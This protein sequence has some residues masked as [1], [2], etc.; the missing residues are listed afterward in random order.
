MDKKPKLV[1]IL[2][3][4]VLIY[5]FFHHA[6][7][8][9]LFAASIS[10]A[11]LL[12][13]IMGSL[14]ARLALIGFL[15]FFAVAFYMELP[16]LRK[17]I[18]DRILSELTMFPA[19]IS[20]LRIKMYLNIFHYLHNTASFLIF[21]V[22]II[23][24]VLLFRSIDIEETSSKFS[25][26][27]PLMPTALLFLIL[28]ALSIFWMFVFPLFNLGKYINYIRE[29]GFQAMVFIV[30]LA[31]L[32]A[33]VYTAVSLIRQKAVGYI[34]APV[35]LIMMVLTRISIVPHNYHLMRISYRLDHLFRN[36]L[37]ETLERIVGDVG[38]M[39][40][41]HYSIHLI[42]VLLGT[43]LVIIFILCLREDTVDIVRGRLKGKR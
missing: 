35:L 42:V 23:A 21:L 9:H 41:V 3:G 12:L 30:S 15:L 5:Y 7:S 8:I 16:Y 38:Y 36:G 28:S 34:L 24:V 22:T 43:P 10:I 37:S 32:A 27:T 17:D 29:N 2:S 25:E 20:S 26:K 19:L 1:Y 13:S 14:R 6:N 40:I 11:L 18:F 39:A 4:L 31:F 33:Y